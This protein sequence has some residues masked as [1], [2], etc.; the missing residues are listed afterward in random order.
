MT[1]EELNTLED[2]LS[3]VQFP[4]SNLLDRDQSTLTVAQWNHLSNITH[5][6]DEYHSL[7]FAQQIID[8]QHKLPLKRRFKGNIMET[9]TQTFATNVQHLYTKNDDFISLSSS[10]RSTLL[11][12]TMLSVASFSCCFLAQTSQLLSNSAFFQTMEATYGS[13]SSHYGQL[14]A[15]RLDRDV[16]FVKLI[17]A[18]LIFS[19]F[20]CSTDRAG[21]QQSDPIDSRSIV[22]LQNRYVELTWRYLVHRYDD[23][24]AVRCFS[25]LLRVLFTMQSSLASIED[26]QYSRMID[27]LVQQTQTLLDV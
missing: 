25:N 4:T 12:R 14:T 8:E 26:E 7:S 9:I 23:Q 3:S 5:C 2:A 20:D 6:Y 10:D 11:R 18:L 17:M 16:V 15:E 21:D 22:D 19:T 27:H 24:Q 1:V 13:E